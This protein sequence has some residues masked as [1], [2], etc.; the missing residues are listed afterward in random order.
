MTRYTTGE[1]AKLCD[2]SVRTVQFYDEKGLLKPTDLT[3][4]GR[5]LY[6]QADV[7]RMHTI[8]F[9]KEL[10]FSLKD[11]STLLIDESPRS[12]LQ[13]LVD[14]Q[15][16]SLEQQIEDEKARLERLLELE[17]GLRYINN[18]TIEAIGA[19]ANIMDS[20]IKLR[21]MRIWM[22]FWGLLM[23]VGWVGG[24]IFGIVTGSWIWFAIGLPAA[25]IIGIV[26]S[27]YY[28]TH[29]AY[30][31]PEDH[32]VFRAPFGQM[33]WRPIR[34][35][36]ENSP[37]RPVD[38]RAIA[39]RSMCPPA[40]LSAMAGILSGLRPMARLGSLPLRAKAGLMPA[41]MMCVL[42]KVMRDES[43]LSILEQS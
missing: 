28:Y 29:T 20:K 23:D 27:R 34:H 17:G 33:F 18:P 22:L 14:E 3:D 8:C 12:M 41:N 35:Q 37:V 9:L 31:C 21:N 1:V 2:V 40:I 38:T 15:K 16:R 19:I 42:K 10:G 26:I 25:V 7:Q 39:W 6:S 36:C 32:T 4:G 11:I 30:I 43:P 5:R 13:F 24:L